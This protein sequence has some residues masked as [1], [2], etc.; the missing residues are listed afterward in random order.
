MS[1]HKFIS[2]ICNL[3]VPLK[4]KD[5]PSPIMLKKVFSHM[6]SRI[7]ESKTGS[8]RFKE[9][10]T[11]VL[12]LALEKAMEHGYLQD[13]NDRLSQV[14]ENVQKARKALAKYGRNHSS[15]KG[16]MEM[17]K[18][19]GAPRKGLDWSDISS[20][21]RALEGVYD[22]KT[23]LI[24]LALRHGF[25]SLSPLIKGL[26]EKYMIKKLPSHDSEFSHKPTSEHKF[27]K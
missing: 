17:A 26:R 19:I 27:K 21:F 16:Y 15:R 9:D 20:E 3:P 23:I 8:F 4:K 11:R 14:E 24:R 13:E 5:V 18:I 12:L 7:M 10:E 22:T 25:P 1:V 6:H 2:K